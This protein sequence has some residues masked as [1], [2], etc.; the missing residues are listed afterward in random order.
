MGRKAFKGTGCRGR[1][2]VSRACVSPAVA[3]EAEAPEK[4][5]LWRRMKLYPWDSEVLGVMS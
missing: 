3:C 1:E 5:L 4:S 2:P